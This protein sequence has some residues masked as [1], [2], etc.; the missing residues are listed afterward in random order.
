MNNSYFKFIFSDLPLSV[1]V[2]FSFEVRDSNPTTYKSMWETIENN[3]RTS[4]S[5]LISFYY[6][7]ENE[8]ERNVLKI[9]FRTK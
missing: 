2:A 7:T 5:N 8:F 9:D 4:R 1:A 3:F 6:V